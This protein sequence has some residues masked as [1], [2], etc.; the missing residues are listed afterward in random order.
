MAFF[1]TGKRGRPAVAIDPAV[2]QEAMSP[3]R[4]I[5]Q[6]ALARTLGIHRHTL[7][8]QLALH[9]IAPP[10]FAAISNV[11]L[12]LLLRTFKELKPRSGWRY[13]YAWLADKG[14]RIQQSRVKASLHRIDGL[15]QVLQ[16]R[17]TI[18]RQIYSVPF[19]NYL[20]H[21]DG[22]HKLIRWGIVLHGGADGCD[23]MVCTK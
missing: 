4:K 22:H 3:G 18:N 21:I 1:R 8:K 9:N 13:A 14:L 16:N 12:D 20:W 17:A 5:S 10:S 23:R 2:L 6:S 15:R 19:P 11:D 7:R